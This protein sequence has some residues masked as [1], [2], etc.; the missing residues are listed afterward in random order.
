MHK[1]LTLI[2]LFFTGTAHATPTAPATNTV[3]NKDQA[4]I[5]YQQ[6]CASCHGEDR[7]GLIGPPLIPA[8]FKRLK[9]QSAALVIK[10]GRLATQMPSFAKTLNDHEVEQL[11]QFIFK[12]PETPPSWT[13]ED[14]KK[15]HKIHFPAETL[16]S[17]PVFKAD[18]QNLFVVV[19]LADHH[20]TVLD[21]DKFEPI[22]RFKT[23]NALHGGPKYSSDGRYVY[24]ASRDGWVSK[25]DLYNLKTVAEIRVGIN[26]RNVAV[27]ADNKYVMVGNT[28]PHTAVLL[29]ADDLSP[30]KLIPVQDQQGNTSRVSAVYTAA[31]RNSFILALKDIP[32]VWEIPYQNTNNGKAFKIASLKLDNYLD[33]FFFSQNYRFIIGAARPKGERKIQGGQVIDLQTKQKVT[34]LD[35]PGMPHLSSG[36]T[37]NYKNS[38]VMAIPNIKDG[39]ITIIDMN[40]WSKIKT[41]K[42]LGP[43]FFMRS[44][45]KSPYA[46]VD[47]FFGPHKEAVHIIDK[48]KLEIVKTLRPAP[49]KTA[50]HVEFTKDGQYA[51]LSIWDKD[52]ALVVYNAQTLE[53]VKRLAMKKPSGKYNVYNKTHLDEGTSH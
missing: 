21:G 50:A 1:L 17:T 22:T 8:S 32:E 6:N 35:I 44:H 38:R 12:Q 13:L 14:I 20:V 11:V 24:F 23:H 41:L 7:L 26:T 2:L 9:P 15:S 31:P 30:I 43:G 40:D 45:S 18:M 52:G 53:E 19:E 42:T 10:N 16:S 49:G 4:L 46:W 3:Y 51:L 47:V 36:I 29:N 48:Q 25:Y 34:D 5:L 27:S 39:S 28:L 33:D 37:W